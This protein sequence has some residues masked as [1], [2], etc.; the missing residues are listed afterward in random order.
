MCV[1]V[2]V[3]QPLQPL[4]VE[5]L[6]F[7]GSSKFPWQ[8]WPEYHLDL[9][10]CTKKLPFYNSAIILKHVLPISP[11]TLCC[12]FFF[13]VLQ[14]HYKTMFFV[15]CIS[16]ELTILS[17]FVPTEEVLISLVPRWGPVF[18]LSQSG[19]FH[20]CY[21]SGCYCWLPCSSGKIFSPFPK[22]Y[23]PHTHHTVSD[24]C[25]IDTWQIHSGVCGHMSRRRC[26][27]FFYMY[28]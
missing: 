17:I 22:R 18:L 11:N 2:C 19:F 9:G 26:V 21:I 15:L 27:S 28:K 7:C 10:M 12:F 8:M 13:A 1:Y 20:C 5:A 14:C 23:N 24:P 6:C 4:G 16:Y 3:R 25:L